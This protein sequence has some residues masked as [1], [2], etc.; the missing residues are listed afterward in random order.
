MYVHATSYH[1]DTL[2]CQTKYDY[3]KGQKK[4]RPEHKAI[5]SKFKVVS[6]SSIYF[7]H[8]LMGIDPCAKYGMPMSK[9]AEVKGRKWT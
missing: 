8:S 6:G 3:V 4:L 9:L 1:D 2:M 5:R 7:T